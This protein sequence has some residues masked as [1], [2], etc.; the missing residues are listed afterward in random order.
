[1]SAEAKDLQNKLETRPIV[2][3]SLRLQIELALVLGRYRNAQALAD[4]PHLI[5]GLAP[6][7]QS[8]FQQRYQSLLTDLNK[9]RSHH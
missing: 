9:Y 8:V 3:Q 6:E 5:N 1:M 2:K 4:L 7:A